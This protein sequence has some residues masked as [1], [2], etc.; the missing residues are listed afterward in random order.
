MIAL[1][2]LHGNFLFF[3]RSGWMVF[4]HHIFQP[5]LEEFL[6]VGQ[7]TLNTLFMGDPT[8]ETVSF[9]IPLSIWPSFPNLKSFGNRLE[10]LVIGPPAPHSQL[11]YSLVLVVDPVSRWQLP[12][13]CS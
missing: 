2:W 9:A 1:G 5:E 10:T 3:K 6:V 12:G 4:S 11:A 7:N 13:R 8:I